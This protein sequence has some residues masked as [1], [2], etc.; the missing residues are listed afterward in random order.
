[1][2]NVAHL[3]PS[4]GCG[5]LERVIANLISANKNEN[6]KHIVISLSSNMDF[7]YALP[8]NIE[9]HTLNKKDGLDLFTH[10][11]F[12]KLVNKLNIDVLHTY[13]FATLEYHF[14][15]KFSKIKK[16]IHS[17]HGLG[18][19]DPSGKNK[20][21]N[22]FR[23]FIS[24]LVDDYIVVS[25]DLKNWLIETVGIKSDRIEFIFNGVPVY[26]YI[27]KQNENSFCE[28]VI[29]GR[30]AEVKNHKRLFNS[31]HDL[32]NKHNRENFHCYVVG[33]GPLSGGL[34]NNVLELNMESYVTFLGHQNDVKSIIEK[35]DALIL[36]SDYEAMPMTA[37][38]AMAL[39]VPVICPRV[40]GVEDFLSDNEAI[41]VD[42][43]SVEALTE[44]LLLFMKMN[45]E[46]KS[47]L[48]LQAHNLVESKYS[49]ES[50][51]SKYN[52]MYLQL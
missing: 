42:G 12:L 52:A 47:K 34:K 9:I 11:R 31:L 25:D 26:D 22:A 6:I 13:N 5:G 28:F 20:K 40:G 3:T 38:E 23:K 32:K 39:S 33:D 1:M 16:H 15:A 50:M 18:G 29:V 2:I 36:S 4:F 21:H 8:D 17:D 10:A 41:L 51:V 35:S 7:R 19:D 14:T 30:L 45:H 46:E 44:G 27:E 43:H 49:V 37:L 24:N 48:S